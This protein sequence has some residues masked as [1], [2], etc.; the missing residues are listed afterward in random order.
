ME[1][2]EGPVMEPHGQRHGPRGSPRRVARGG[3]PRAAWGHGHAQAGG[4]SRSDKRSRVEVRFGEHAEGRCDGP[5]YRVTS[6]Q[7]PPG[8]LSFLERLASR[9]KWIPGGFLVQPRGHTGGSPTLARV[10]CDGDLLLQGASQPPAGTVSDTQPSLREAPASFPAPPR[11]PEQARAGGPL[12][13]RSATP[14]SPV[15]VPHLLGPARPSPHSPASQA[16]PSL[17]RNLLSSLQGLRPAI[18]TEI[19][20]FKP[21]IG[22]AWDQQAH[23]QER[24]RG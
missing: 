17:S 18:S 23:S 11:P 12:G 8:I 3:A 24:L 5:L 13:P 10:H 20:W 2:L 14:R 4:G 16:C 9:R 21:T 15:W 7:H 19:L 22:T 6:L 1:L